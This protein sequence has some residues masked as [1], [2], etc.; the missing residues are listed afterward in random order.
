MLTPAHAHTH[1]DTQYTHTFLAHTNT[2]THTHTMCML[3]PTPAHTHTH[4][5]AH[6]HTHSHHH[7]HPNTQSY[8]HTHN[9]NPLTTHFQPKPNTSCFPLCYSHRLPVSFPSTSFMVVTVAQNLAMTPSLSLCLH[10]TPMTKCLAHPYHILLHFWPVSPS[11]EEFFS[12]NKCLLFSVL[13]NW[14]IDTQ[15]LKGGSNRSA[16]SLAGKGL[17][18]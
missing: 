5:H 14:L 12:Q 4:T 9:S 2:H 13:I 11:H 1:T 18:K 6:T 15:I 16:N 3:T 17:K 8:T 10:M 7:H